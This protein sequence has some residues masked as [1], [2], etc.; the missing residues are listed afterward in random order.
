MLHGAGGLV[1]S[2]EVWSRVL[3][4]MGVATFAIDSHSG[5]NLDNIGAKQGEL[6]FFAYTLDAYRAQELLAAP[7]IDPGRI[8]L[9]AHRVAGE[10]LSIPASNGFGTPG[11]EGRT[12]RPTSHFTRLAKAPP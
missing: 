8:A 9:M 4:A 12:S 11:R 1:A 7:G 5:R 6:G 10:A 2:N 3:N